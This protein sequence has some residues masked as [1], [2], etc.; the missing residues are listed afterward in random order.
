MVRAGSGSALPALLLGAVA[1]LAAGAARAE[2][3]HVGAASSLRQPIEQIARSFEA[4]NPGMRVA[5][6]YGASSLLAGVAARPQLNLPD[7]IH[8]NAEGYEIVAKTVADAV[9]PLLKEMQ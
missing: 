1:M 4:G 8:P 5:L 7:G 9:A 3:V 6:Y 2:T